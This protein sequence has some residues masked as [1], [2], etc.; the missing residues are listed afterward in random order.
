LKKVITPQQ[1]LQRLRQTAL[2]GCRLT[3]EALRWIAGQD[4]YLPG[5]GT[6]FRLMRENICKTFIDPK[7]AKPWSG[8]GQSC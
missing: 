7:E 3:I 5:F 1:R 4:V 2:C 6:K 8:K